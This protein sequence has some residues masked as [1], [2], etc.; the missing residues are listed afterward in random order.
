MKKVEFRYDISVVTYIQKR[1]K[2]IFSNSFQMDKV[3]GTILHG[4]EVRTI[5]Y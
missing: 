2:D 3:L 1:E 5:T 4:I